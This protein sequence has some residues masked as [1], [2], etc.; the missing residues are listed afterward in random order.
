MCTDNGEMIVCENSGQYKAFILDSPMGNSIESIVSIDKGVLV[1]VGQSFYIYR[2]SDV[3]IRAPIK[4]LGERCTL[5][6]LNEPSHLEANN[7][8]ESMCIN[9]R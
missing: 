8:I 4:L 1:A 3:D 6:I 5:T 7:I 9:S 2:N